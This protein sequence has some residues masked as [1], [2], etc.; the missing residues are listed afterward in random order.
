MFRSKALRSSMADT[1]RS[2]ACQQRHRAKEERG[3]KRS[4]SSLGGMSTS[5][6]RI[7]APRPRRQLNATRSSR[8]TFI[9][10]KG[11]YSEKY[12]L[13]DGRGRIW[14]AKIG[15]EAQSETAAVRLLSAV[16]Y[17]TEVNYLVPR[18]AI[19]GKGNLHECPSRARPR[20]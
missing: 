14:V 3:G 18:L 5:R 19:P 9:K 11:G 8:I 7:C 4:C 16:G 2:V 15:N 10:E 20:R 12:R 1:R 13:K 17:K 6:V